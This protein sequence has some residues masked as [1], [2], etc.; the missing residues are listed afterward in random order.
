LLITYRV[1]KKRVLTTATIKDLEE[2]ET[3]LRTTNA[4][5]EL[6]LARQPT[7]SSTPEYPHAPLP[8]IDTEL[9]RV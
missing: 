7:G 9:K 8:D 2:R 4:H 6:I 3:F 1:L 5:S